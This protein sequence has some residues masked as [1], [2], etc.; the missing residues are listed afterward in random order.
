[1]WISGWISRILQ[2]YEIKSKSPPTMWMDIRIS[3]WI[4]GILQTDEMKSN[5]PHWSACRL[6]G[7][8]PR[9]PNVRLIDSVQINILRPELV[10]K[11]SL[12]LENTTT[13][14]EY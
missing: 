2:T 11:Y 10:V 3:V 14:L 13:L 8:L 7:A 1:M 9:V 4:S 6:T 12:S 5:P